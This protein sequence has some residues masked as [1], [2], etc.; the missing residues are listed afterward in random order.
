MIYRRPD[1]GGSSEG[2][3]AGKNVERCF[4]VTEQRDSLIIHGE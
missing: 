2:S 4:P 3:L 1:H